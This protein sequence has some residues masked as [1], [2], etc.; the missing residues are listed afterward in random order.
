MKAVFLASAIGCFAGAYLAHL[1]GW[2]GLSLFALDF[3]IFP[4]AATV[5]G[6]VG[7]LV[8]PVIGAIILTMF[9]EM[10]RE[11]GPLRVVF[12]S[13]ILAGLVIL[14][15]GGLVPYLQRKYHQFEHWM[16]I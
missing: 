5:V 7:T 15:T 13:L 3:S 10:L 14:N 8:G 16:E 4:I 12:Y 11:F 2:V 6:G 1:Y 9:S